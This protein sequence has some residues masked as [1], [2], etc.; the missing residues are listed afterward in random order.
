MYPD[1]TNRPGSM[2]PGKVVTYVPGTKC[3]PM[4]PD[5]T[6]FTVYC[7]LFTVLSIPKHKKDGAGHHREG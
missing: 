2:N 1:H 3:L 5:H 7:L 6:L 4:Y